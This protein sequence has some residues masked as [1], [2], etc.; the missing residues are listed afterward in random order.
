MKINKNFLRVCACVCVVLFWLLWW[1]VRTSDRFCSWQLWEGAKH[2]LC[3][4]FFPISQGI[5][6]LQGGG[7]KWLALAHTGLG[8]TTSLKNALNIHQPNVH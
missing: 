1:Q 7:V 8:S 5:L 2:P 4:L 6:D 3:T